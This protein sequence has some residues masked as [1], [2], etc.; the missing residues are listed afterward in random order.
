ML[1]DRELIS[2]LNEKAMHVEKINMVEGYKGEHVEKGE[3]S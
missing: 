2:G 1:E 3:C